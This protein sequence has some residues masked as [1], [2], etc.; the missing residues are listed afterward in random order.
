MEKQQKK[1]SMSAGLTHCWLTHSL[2]DM[3]DWLARSLQH[4]LATN[5]CHHH[6]AR[7]LCN[8]NLSSDLSQMGM[9]RSFWLI[10]TKGTFIRS[11]PASTLDF[12]GRNP[13]AEARTSLRAELPH[14][15]SCSAVR[16]VLCAGP[17]W[18]PG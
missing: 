11:A 2:T 16:C 3:A 15:P 10:S 17:V 12:E 18:A 8:M 14:S 6:S 5:N 4:N 9:L 13:H 1:M 7:A